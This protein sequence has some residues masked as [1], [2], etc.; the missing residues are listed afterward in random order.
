MEVSE[1][2]FG[3]TDEDLSRQQNEGSNPSRFFFDKPRKDTMNVAAAL[4]V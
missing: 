3:P 1:T 2:L 4:W